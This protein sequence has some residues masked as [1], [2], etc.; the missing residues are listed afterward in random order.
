MLPPC[1]IYNPEDTNLKHLPASNRKYFC[2][3]VQ[4]LEMG[5]DLLMTVGLVEPADG[6]FMWWFSLQDCVLDPRRVKTW[7]SPCRL[8]EKEDF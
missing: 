7:R 8:C 4:I 3:D 5:S 6:L 2:S 1:F